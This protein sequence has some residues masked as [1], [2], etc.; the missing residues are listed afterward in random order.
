MSSSLSMYWVHSSVLALHCASMG[1]RL[2]ISSDR[3]VNSG[4][5]MKLLKP[6]WFFATFVVSR[7]HRK[8]TGKFFSFSRSPYRKNSSKSKYVHCF[9]VLKFRVGTE[10]SAACK[11]ISSSCCCEAKIVLPLVL[12]MN[13]LPFLAAALISSWPIFV[14]THVKSC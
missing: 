8:D 3:V 12:S 7:S 4:I 2:G 14:L 9:T 6:G 5:T 11:E 1:L 10:R 13:R